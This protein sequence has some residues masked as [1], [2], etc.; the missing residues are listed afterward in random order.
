LTLLAG[1][2]IDS[3]LRTQGYFFRRFWW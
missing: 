3:A 1:Y 2:K